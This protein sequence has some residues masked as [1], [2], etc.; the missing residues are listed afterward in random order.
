MNKWIITGRLTKD[1][2]LKVS[3]SGREYTNFS[4]AVDRDYKDKDGNRPVDFVPCSAFGKTAAFINQW[5]HKGDGINL[6][7]SGEFRK[8]EKDGENRTVCSF[9]V[10]SVEF[11]HSKG[12]ASSDGAGATQSEPTVLTGTDKDLPF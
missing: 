11:P 7:G 6:V 2:E 3:D 8:Y 5:F 10:D 12:K 9:K 1:T 4:V